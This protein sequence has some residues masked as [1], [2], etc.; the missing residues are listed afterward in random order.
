MFDYKLI[1]AMAVVIQEGGFERAGQR[2]HISQSAVSQRVK[3]LEE[4][5]G[6]ILM[7]RSTPPKPTAA[8][9][10][11]LKHY[12]QVL[13]L[14]QG[15]RETLLPESGTRSAVLAIGINAD[16]LAT[17]FLG[18][19]RPLL[20]A[21]P[22]TLD[23][24]VADQDQTL[25]YLKAGEVMGCISTHDQPVQGCSMS[26]LGRMDYRLLATP[27]FRQRW[28]A[29]GL[30]REA[31]AAAPAVL[32]NRQDRL[33]HKLLS[34][35]LGPPPASFPCHYLPSS[36]QLVAMLLAGLA[37][38]A[39][40]DIQGQ[41]QLTGGRLVELLPGSSYPVA[42]Y[43]HAWSHR[44]RLLAELSGLLTAQAGSGLNGE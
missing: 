44:S 18:A 13:S 43:W 12:Q 8:G 24:K 40:P 7:I 16:S 37:Y 17:W 10:V 14:E 21:E 6:R 4:Q 39:V 35:L 30:S 2:L 29:R 5:S 32:F 42:L 25:N 38:G 15:V 11:L 26:P 22:L 23:L 9:Q 41:P 34:R 31:L 27:A 1:Q 19:V 33:H 28:F 20:E 36:E 3:Q